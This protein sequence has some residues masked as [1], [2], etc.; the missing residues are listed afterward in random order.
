MCS[1]PYKADNANVDDAG[2]RW[3]VHTHERGGR[4]MLWGG[5][6]PVVSK[7]AGRAGPGF[8]SQWR[9]KLTYRP[10]VKIEM[11]EIGG[12]KRK[13]GHRARESGIAVCFSPQGSGAQS[14]CE[15]RTSMLKTVWYENRTQVGT[16][17]TR[18]TYREAWWSVVN[19]LSGLEFSP[20]LGAKII[21]AYARNQKVTARHV[22]T[23]STK[24]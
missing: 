17:V 16:R 6:E 7:V 20:W 3:M 13:C 23:N 2:L 4:S 19:L 21:H 24:T 1:C 15:L 10:R 5:V 22:V 18:N 9:R 12:G 14:E 8:F 11:L